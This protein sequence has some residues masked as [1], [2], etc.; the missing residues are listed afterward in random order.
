[1]AEEDIDARAEKTLK[2]FKNAQAEAE[3]GILLWTMTA[4]GW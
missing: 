1:M 4:K 3:T 2:L